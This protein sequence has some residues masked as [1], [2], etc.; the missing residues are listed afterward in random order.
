MLALVKPTATALLPDVRRAASQ[1]LPSLT[2][3]IFSAWGSRS[4]WPD[5]MGVGGT[6][7][8]F[9]APQDAP[10]MSWHLSKAELNATNNL[11][12]MESL[13][14]SQGPLRFRLVA[15]CQGPFV[16][17][18]LRPACS[19]SLNM[20]KLQLDATL[21]LFGTSH[22]LTTSVNEH[23]WIHKGLVVDISELPEN[24]NIQLSLNRFV[25]ALNRDNC[26]LGT[27]PNESLA[28]D[29]VPS[30]QVPRRQE[31][32]QPTALPLLLP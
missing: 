21:S 3:S 32:T 30:K 16:K 20:D 17:I 6:V 27:V 10:A 23:N 13:W 31:T 7:S 25:A 11:Y 4:I 24:I 8:M 19:P 15:Y 5:H 26:H 1:M 18:C 28:L 12:P 2:R 14:C 9:N 29:L 22:Y